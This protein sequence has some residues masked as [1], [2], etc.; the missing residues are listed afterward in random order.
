M[1]KKYDIVIVGAGPA[2]LYAAYNFVKKGGK[3]KVLIID[4]GHSLIKRKCPITE[5]KVPTCIKCATCSI[6]SGEGGAGA[7]SDGKFNITNEFG[8]SLWEKIGKDAAINIL[9]KLNR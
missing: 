6:M 3:G 9:K 4:K 2:G 1:E 8:G 7:Y 5:G